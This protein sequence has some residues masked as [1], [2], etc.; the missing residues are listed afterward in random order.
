MHRNNRHL[1]PKKK[2]NKISKPYVPI[3][4]IYEQ[5]EPS[6][7]TSPILSID[8]SPDYLSILEKM[9]TEE[10]SLALK[11]PSIKPSEARILFERLQPH[12]RR[13]FLEELALHEHS[14]NTT[15]GYDGGGSRSPLRSGLLAYYK[16]DNNWLDSSGNGYHLEAYPGLP[17][18][19][20]TESGIISNAVRF[21]ANKTYL[22]NTNIKFPNNWSASYWVYVIN[23]DY[24]SNDPEDPFGG[25]AF[26]CFIDIGGAVLGNQ[27][28]VAVAGDKNS[29]SGWVYETFT[30]SN[31]GQFQAID[32]N[33]WYHFCIIQTTTGLKWYK[34]GVSI[35]FL[36][37][38]GSR[39][40]NGGLVI[41]AQGGQGDFDGN[42]GN[43]R[44]DEVGFWNR[45]LS[46][47]DVQQLYSNGAGRTFPFGS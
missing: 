31:W 4:S 27:R 6:I 5:V 30:E 12:Q 10:I 16:F 14:L 40:T 3:S 7:K 46:I 33:K 26:P 23:N 2:Q 29:T 25:I 18:N 37:S 19:I 38:L 17:S 9:S 1:P 8:L 44:I 28:I 35:P 21:N 15:G 20:T 42:Q 47:N 32:L 43:Y 45:A 11:S 13:A 34:N 24:I 36:D 22:R 41:G 39:P